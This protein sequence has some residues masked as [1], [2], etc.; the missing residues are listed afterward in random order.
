MFDF[1]DHY[2][3]GDYCRTS[4]KRLGADLEVVMAKLEE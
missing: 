2:F 1:Y 3:W 4:F